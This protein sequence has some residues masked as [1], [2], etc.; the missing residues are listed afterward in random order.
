MCAQGETDT[1]TLH[2]VMHQGF[3]EI[4]DG[5]DLAQTEVFALIPTYNQLQSI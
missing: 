1:N 2:H 5:R 4:S 3:N